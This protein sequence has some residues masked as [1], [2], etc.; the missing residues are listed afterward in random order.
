MQT[1]KEIETR[2][3]QSERVESSIWNPRR[4]EREKGRGARFEDTMA[5]NFPELVKDTSPQTQAQ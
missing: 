4:R 3:G 2:G 1:V 5:E